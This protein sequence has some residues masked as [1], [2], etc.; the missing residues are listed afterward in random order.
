MRGTLHTVA[1]DDLRA[2]LSLTAERTIRSTARRREQLGLDDATIDRAHDAAVAAL[3]GGGA[4]PRDGML[5]AFRDAGLDTDQG[6]GYHLLFH[7][8]QRGLIAWGPTSDSG[9]AVVLL[10]EWAPA[11]RPV[12]GR[13]SALLL[14]LTGYLRGRGPATLAD[15]VAWTKLTLGDARTALAAAGDSIVP[16]DATRY[17]LADAPAAGS[18]ATAH[19]LPG[20]DE[21]LLGYADR[22][23]VIADEHFERVVPGSNGMFLPMVVVRGQVV[24][25]WKRAGSGART[26]VAVTPF[27]EY[28]DAERRAVAAAVER[29]AAFSGTG[30]DVEYA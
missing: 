11:T 6:R 10:D 30:A 13:E 15:F 22:S 12:P 29:H 4:L 28:G 21:Y 2:L 14:A 18:V 17:A 16:V 8:S 3:S 19:L 7:L 27:R 25:T 1:P 26:R 5:A 20:F 9:Q 23:A 24:G